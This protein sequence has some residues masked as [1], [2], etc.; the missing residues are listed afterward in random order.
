MNSKNREENKKEEKGERIRGDRITD[1]KRERRGDKNCCTRL[2][3]KGKQ[4][5]RGRGRGR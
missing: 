4:G 2:D 3:M 1:K 5:E